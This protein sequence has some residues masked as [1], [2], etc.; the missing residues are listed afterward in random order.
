MK[1]IMLF[2]GDIMPFLTENED[3][4][5]TLRPKLLDVLNNSKRVP[6]FGL[7]LLLQ[8]TGVSLLSK[9]ATTWKEMAL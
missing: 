5:A 2:F 9:H 8:W 7:S 6:V 4:G 1:Q 3:V